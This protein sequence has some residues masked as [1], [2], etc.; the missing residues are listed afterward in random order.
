MQQDAPHKRYTSG[1]F[2]TEELEQEYL[3]VTNQL[4]Y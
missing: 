1:I 2:S 3:M 4:I